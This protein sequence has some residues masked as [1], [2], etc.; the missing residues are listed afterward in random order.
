VGVVKPRR[1]KTEAAADEKRIPPPYGKMSPSARTLLA[2]MKY[3]DASRAQVRACMGLSQS[4]V[5][6]LMRN[7]RKDEFCRYVIKGG[8]PAMYG[9]ALEDGVYVTCS[10]CKCRVNWVPCVACCTHKEEFIDRIDKKIME[11]GEPI[12]PESQEPT[13]YLPGSS[14]KVAVMKYRV[15]MGMQP[16]CSRDAKGVRRV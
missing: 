2:L 13:K 1:D 16:F 9:E 7:M 14:Q 4:D 12:P 10:K 15:E 3:T 5:N 8:L 11:Y 6:K